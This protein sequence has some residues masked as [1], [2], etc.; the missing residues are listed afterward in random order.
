MFKWYALVFKRTLQSGSGNGGGGG[1]G[2]GGSGGMRYEAR[3]KI[4]AFLA[5][6]LN[7]INIQWWNKTRI[8]LLDLKHIIIDVNS[9]V[10][11]Y[12]DHMYIYINIYI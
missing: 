7:E 9:V 8:D 5:Y 6:L 12:V 4:R 1:G 2:D 3:D 10:L 11:L